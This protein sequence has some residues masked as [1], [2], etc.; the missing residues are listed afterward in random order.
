MKDLIYTSPYKSSVNSKQLLSHPS[1]GLAFCNRKIRGH[2]LTRQESS[3]G[4]SR[5]FY[6]QMPQH[7]LH[8]SLPSLRGRANLIEIFWGEI[9]TIL[10]FYGVELDRK[11][12]EEADVLQRGKDFPPQRVT[13]VSDSPLSSIEQ[14]Q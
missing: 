11:A 2:A 1:N 3:K 14:Q 7:G 8:R 5:A 13:Q 10:P 12:L 4:H 6:P 9:G